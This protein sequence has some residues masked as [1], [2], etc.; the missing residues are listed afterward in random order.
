MTRGQLA[1]IVAQ[2]AGFTDPV[3]STQQTFEDVPTGYSVWSS[4]ERVSG[5]GIISGY[6]CGGVNE[7]CVPPLN[8]PYFRP[9]NNATRAQISKIVGISAGFQEAVPSAQQ[10]FE[11]VPGTSTFWIYI[12]RMAGRGIIGGYPCGSPG[13]PCVAPLNRPYFR[14]NNNATRGQISKITSLAF[15]PGCNPLSR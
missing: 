3:A 11:D 1:K 15:F 8:R 7:P 5:H 4:I 9:G 14:P 13:E 2:S 10:T 12:E 6:P